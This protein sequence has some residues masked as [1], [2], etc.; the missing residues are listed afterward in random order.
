MKQIGDRETS[1]EFCGGYGVRMVS[2]VKWL[3]GEE[4][5]W[6]LGEKGR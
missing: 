4:R 6:R 2:G 1:I 3:E 5:D